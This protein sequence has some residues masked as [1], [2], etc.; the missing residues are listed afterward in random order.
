MSIERSFYVD[1]CLQSLPSVEKAQHLVDKPTSLL[2]TGGSG[3]RQAASN[4]PEA[5]SHLPREARSESSELR[6]NESDTDPQ[7]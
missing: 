3:L 4:T 7:D 2:T 1:N 5:L 6:L